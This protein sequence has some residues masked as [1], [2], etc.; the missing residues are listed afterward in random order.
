MGKLLKYEIKGSY[1]TFM[2]VFA[3]MILLSL[4][5][6]FKIDA[7]NIIGRTIAL[8]L[9]DVAAFMAILL[10][11]VGL[12][13]KEMYEDRGYLT[14][15]LPVN[16]R[17]FLGAKLVSSLLWFLVASVISLIFL[18]FIPTEDLRAQIIQSLSTYINWKAVSL[19]VL[20]ELFSGIFFMTII[21]F[22]ITISKIALKNKT[23]GK[24][25]GFVVFVAVNIF[26]SFTSSKL[27]QAFPQ[28]INIGLSKMNNALILEGSKLSIDMPSINIVAAVFSIIFMIALFWTTSYLIDNKIE[29]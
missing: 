14:F 4:F 12:F 25:T 2:I 17:N 8:A 24:L 15:T 6:L 21:F 1:K 5:L 28:E 13:N 23:A 11:I 10:M 20:S 27:M 19:N 29:I 18:Y 9:V 26:Y 22:S 3:S 7:S 16:G